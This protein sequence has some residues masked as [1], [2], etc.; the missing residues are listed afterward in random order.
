MNQRVLV[1]GG[2]GFIG[3]RV[4]T[5]LAGDP[6]LSVIAAGRSPPASRTEGVDAQILDATDEFAL[7]RAMAD[8]TA[9]VNCVAADPDTIV[10]SARALFSAA[11]QI[12][13]A[14]RIVH[15]SSLAAY[16]SV[17]GAVDETVAARGD[18]GP[19]SAAKLKTESLALDCATAV[20]LR[21]GIVYG[22][23]SPWWS[24]R[25]AR[26]LLARRIGDLGEAGMGLCNLVHVDD[27]ASAVLRAVRL[28]TIESRI[29]NLGLPSAPTWNDYFVRYGGA[30]GVPARRI[31]ASRL[32]A[33]RYLLAAPLKLLELSGHLGLFRQATLPPP[34]RPWLLS[35]CRHRIGMVAGR[36]EK[37]LGMRWTP[38]DQG[39]QGTADWFLAGGRT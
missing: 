35:L 33:E 37:E 4:V 5:R 22:P 25:I 15:L 38:L 11:A 12:S 10:R 32:A 3:R 14:P 23:R 26:L 20:T 1:L 34:I 18:L 36:A 27:V 16:G 21:P 7:R 28:P 39:L 9:V 24:D 6:G 30:L 13:P 29:F 17:C 2:N 8:V 19:Y 31:S